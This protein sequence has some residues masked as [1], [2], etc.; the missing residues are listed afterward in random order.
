MA[1]S[2][3]YLFDEHTQITRS[4]VTLDGSAGATIIFRGWGRLWF[5][6]SSAETI[7]VSNIH[8]RGIQFDMAGVEPQS[9]EQVDLR[10][11]HG[12]SVTESVFGTRPLFAEIATL[13]FEGGRDG[14]VLNNRFIDGFLQ[15]NPLG[16]ASPNTGFVVSGNDFDSGSILI[17]GQSNSRIVNNRIHNTRRGN[18]VHIRVAPAYLGTIEN[19]EIANNT[20]DG[21]AGQSNG[22]MIAGLPED[23]GGKGTVRGFYIRN[24]T[25]RGTTANINVQVAA[26]AGQLEDCLQNCQDISDTYD[27]E[28]RGNSLFAAWNGTGIDLRGGTYGVVNGGQVYEN[29]LDTGTP[30][31]S[32]WIA[33]D[34]HTSNVTIGVNNSD[35]PIIISNQ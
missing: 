14:R 20:V 13:I 26:T 25:V 2:G 7:P 23:P 27:I 4:N 6:S 22:A 8:L 5:S 17:I 33:L 12:C 29:N 11:C 24:N 10:N 30:G 32:H 28:I 19:V 9:R 18:F 1:L 15:L 34:A 16:S 35:Q 31:S 3:Y 21:L